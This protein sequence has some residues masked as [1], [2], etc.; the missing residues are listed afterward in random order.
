M[1]RMTGRR[2]SLVVFAGLALGAA[3]LAAD[4]LP[5]SSTG[6]AV[7]HA[8]AVLAATQGQKAVGL[9]HFRREAAG[10]RVSGEV[11]GL[12]P[13]SKHGFHVHEFGDCSAPDGASAGGHFAPETHPHGAPDPAAHHAGDLGNLEADAAGKATIDVLVPGLS[14]ASGARALIGRGLIVH[15]QPDDL[16]TQPTGNA[17]ARVACGVIGVAKP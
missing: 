8:V 5:A 3:V 15:A 2:C 14:V 9:V 10:V 17:G 16:T 4:P 6:D 13:S 11:T 7:T 1:R 12:A